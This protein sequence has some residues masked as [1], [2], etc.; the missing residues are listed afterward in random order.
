MEKKKRGGKAKYI[1]LG[2]VI[3]T[4]LLY[5]MTD[6]IT[7]YLWFKELGYT[8]VF[9]TEILTKIKLGVPIFLVLTVLAYI[10]LSILK[11]N[12]LKRTELEIVD[13][14]SE[15]SLRTV[16][17]LLSCVFG[18][19]L[20]I[21]TITALWFQILQFMNST[22]FNI[23]D[24]IFGLDL[25]FYMFK[26]EFLTALNG[27]A[28]N[29][30]VTLLGI[31]LLFY[32]LLIS[33]TK[34]KPGTASEAE[35]A[36]TYDYDIPEEDFVQED[37]PKTLGDYFDSLFKKTGGVKKRVNPGENRLGKILITV[38]STQLT[39]ISVLL[40]A[41]IGIGF[42]LR[43]YNLLY[44]GTGVA[45]GAGYTDINITLWVYRILMVLAVVAA[46]TFSLGLRKRKIKLAL[47][48]P[49]LMIIISLIGGGSVGLVQ[50]L[51]VSPDE[52]NKESEYLQNNITFTRMAYDLQDILITD[53]AADNR[54][55]KIDVLN[56]MDTFS[57]IRI[58]DF[59][60]AERFYNQTQ[61]IR[62]YYTFNDVDVDRYY[63]NG[64]YTQVFLSAREIDQ[65][66]IE[67]QWLIRHLK[68]THGYGIT[69]S[70]VDRVTSSGQPDMLIDSIP[71]VSDVAEI[72][73]E[74][75]EI[76]FGESTNDYIIIGTSEA[77]FDY[78]S[79]ESNTY[80]FYEG[81]AGIKLGF[82]NRILFAIRE[83][84]LKI[85]VSTNITTDSRILINRNIEERVQNI[86]P[87]LAYD[88]D[89]YVVVADGQ[90][91]WIMDAYTM[92]SYYPYSEPWSKGSDMNYI[93]NSVKIVVNAYD[94]D[95]S[96]Y[97][98][99]EEDPMVLTL[100]KI[101]PK[102]FKNF[103]D[104]PEYLKAHVHYPN[105]LFNIQAEVYEKYHM[106]DVEVF[107][108]N[109]D[110]WS[111]ANETYGQAEQPMTP[112]YFI[113]RLPGQEKA[114]FINSIPYTPSGKANMTGLL[115]ARNDGENYG[116]LILYRL[117][118]DRIIYGPAQIE[119]QI[120]QD[121]EISKEFSL[122]NN[123]GSTYS[124]GNM[125]VFPV[126][127]SLLYV[128]PVYLEASQGSLPEVK[129]VIVYY[130][131]RIAYEPTLAEALDT[132]FGDG[133]GDP[134]NTDNPIEE[135]RA[136]A[137]ILEAGGVVPP[138]V[139]GDNGQEPGGET[140]VTDITQLAALASEAYENALAAQKAGDWAGYGKYM[141]E[142]QQYLDQ[143]VQ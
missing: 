34:A 83:R 102:L 108:Q 133:T 15:K 9:F 126:E 47:A 124:R 51:V 65:A 79:G 46:L 48:A 76:Y 122:W 36:Q 1:F 95:V 131:E 111:I 68:Y 14:E 3:L 24:P 130:G 128:E 32:A 33:F 31:T 107:Y 39:V 100:A 72:K 18:A 120:N 97:I 103:D 5:K 86:A 2:L 142:L 50:N 134:L 125:F 28:I 25:G 71:P 62:T 80:N 94:G 101:Y 140:P 6:F 92:S 135:G 49:A 35:E 116:E 113:M 70:R 129:R 44:S 10:F 127:G 87:F 16:A 41:G 37:K 4:T 30:L 96:F 43:Q 19:V 121:A 54:L 69:L 132:L 141:E 110:L 12:F 21:T 119:A 99:D 55:S 89:P 118:K 106:T 67:D 56:N 139:P 88:D 93:R 40:F 143:M 109:E 137:A 74:R 98:A 91:Y 81:E 115:V 85:L 73:I 52:I 57:N 53:F 114:E 27:A 17:I 64:E 58:N 8:S 45:Y 26:L 59:D 105:A 63:V 82:F 11:R 75:P 38:A 104:M 61:S 7:E 60:P 84:S 66:K 123:S 112:N 78:P 42:Y 29:M 23:A 138:V 77:E 117:P 90:I 13:E 20:S 22:A 136:A